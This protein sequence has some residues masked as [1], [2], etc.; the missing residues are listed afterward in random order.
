VIDEEALLARTAELAVDYLRGLPERPVHPL[1][2]IA[3]L[4][5]ALGGPLPEEPSHPREVIERLAADADA[6]LLASQGGR[7][8][9]FVIGGSLPAALAADWLVSTWDQD[10]V[11]ATLGPAAAVIEEIAGA[12]VA[13]LLGI[14]PTASFAFTTG[15][16]MAHVTCLAAA[17]HHVLAEAGWDVAEHGL[18]GA[19]AIRVLVGGQRHATLDRALRLLGIGRTA[20]VTVAADDQGR[21]RTEALREALLDLQSPLIVCAQAGEVNTGACDDLEAVADAAA[22]AGAWLH[23]DGAFGLWAAASPSLAHLT[24]GHERADSWALDGHKWLN[25]PYDCGVA[26]CAHR[27]S[28]RTAMSSQAAYYVYDPDAAREPMD[29]TP[30]SSRRAR[31]IPVYAAIRQLGRSGIAELVERCCSHARLFA[32]GLSR[33]PGCEI[34]NDVVLNQV[35]LRFEDDE[36]TRAVLAAVQRSGEAWM[37]G[38]TWDGRAAIRISVSGWRT[39]R[40]DVERTVAAFARAARG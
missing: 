14:P 5:E 32:E 30:E 39:T 4:R 10:L 19:P 34:L 25:V 38:T 24:R 13:K 17:R 6:G 40:D 21:M 1:P 3:E 37:G 11:F 18:T 12:W 36:R 2:D 23:V 15:C 26:Y 29:W 28:H 20:I 9:G 22:G 27:D 8:F 33:L 35:L 7:Y 31:S 16:Q